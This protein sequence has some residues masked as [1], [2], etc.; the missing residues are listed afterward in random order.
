MAQCDRVQGST[1]AQGDVALDVAACLLDSVA[2][3]SNLQRWLVVARRRHDVCRILSMSPA[4][5]TNDQLERG[6][7]CLRVKTGDQ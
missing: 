2:C 5:C 7:H 6:L 4:G 1:G 3:T